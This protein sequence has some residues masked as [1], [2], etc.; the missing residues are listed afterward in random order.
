MLGPAET[1][2][3]DEEIFKDLLKVEENIRNLLK[4]LVNWVEEDVY[5]I[6]PDL[7]FYD[8]DLI[9]LRLPTLVQYLEDL[10]QERKDSENFYKAAERPA[11]A[12]RSVRGVCE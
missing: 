7:M 8:F 10:E 11:Q 2:R 3:T 4:L 12:T 6:D 1:P 5:S 9:K